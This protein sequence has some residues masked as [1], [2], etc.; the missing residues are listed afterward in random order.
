[1]NWTDGITDFFV[2][3]GTLIPDSDGCLGGVIRNLVEPV[4]SP[5]I[6]V[7]PPKAEVN[8]EH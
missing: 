8:S 2:S 6:S 4:T 1:M 5:A 7:M 3:D